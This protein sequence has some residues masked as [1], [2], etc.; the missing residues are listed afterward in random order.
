MPALKAHFLRYFWV[1]SC[2]RET[3]SLSAAHLPIERD[4][5]QLLVALVDP[6]DLRIIDDLTSLVGAPIVPVISTPEDILEH[7]EISYR[8]TET[9]GDNV[10]PDDLLT[11][12]PAATTDIRT[13]SLERSS[14]HGASMNTTT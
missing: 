2:P 7:I 11:I 8:L 12:N 1:K 9:L 3:L 4:A 13:A 10:S 14:Q 5:G 6:T